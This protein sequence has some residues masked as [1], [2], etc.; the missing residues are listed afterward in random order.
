[1]LCCAE[2]AVLLFAQGA[3]Q[4]MWWSPV[5]RKS[6]VVPRSLKAEGTLRAILRDAGIPH[7]KYKK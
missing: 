3:K 6:F 1:M 4:E 2:A 7:P 5:T